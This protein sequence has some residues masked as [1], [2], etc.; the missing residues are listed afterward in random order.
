MADVVVADWQLQLQLWCCVRV[1]RRRTE[2]VRAEFHQGPRTLCGYHGR[3]CS[4]GTALAP[5]FGSV[6]TRKAEEAKRLPRAGELRWLRNLRSQ[7]CHTKY[8]PYTL[9]QNT[10]LLIP[11]NPP[12]LYRNQNCPLSPSY[13]DLRA[14]GAPIDK[15]QTVFSTLRCRTKT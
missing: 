6:S 14:P 3:H 10:Q 11:F 9:H 2:A 8:P 13:I 5:G 12:F 1:P 15:L 4:T 7:L